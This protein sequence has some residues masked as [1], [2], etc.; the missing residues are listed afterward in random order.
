[1]VTDKGDKYQLMRV[2]DASGSEIKFQLF[3]F[4][5][6]KL[7]YSDGTLIQFRN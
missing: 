7:I 3:N 1:M 4:G 2:L 6:A 5:D